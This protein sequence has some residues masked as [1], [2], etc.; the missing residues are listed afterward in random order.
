MR[1]I[2]ILDPPGGPGMTENGNFVGLITPGGTIALIAFATMVAGFHGG[3]LYIG[4]ARVLVGPW[5]VRGLMLGTA[6]LLIF[7]SDLITASNRDFHRFATAGWNIGLFGGLVVAGGVVA[8]GVAARLERALPRIDAAREEYAL[9][10]GALAIIGVAVISLVLADGRPLLSGTFGS[11]ML[12]GIAIHLVPSPR[13]MWMGRLSLAI[14]A[15][16]GALALTGEVTE[17]LR[18]E[19]SFSGRQS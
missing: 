17:I 7:G 2:A 9:A 11:A 4:F 10:G 15:A 1:L 8:A 6:M 5:L 14:M 3:L 18:L 19:A 12:V 13:V 16:L